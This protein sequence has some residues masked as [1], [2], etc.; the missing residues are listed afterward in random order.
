MVTARL[1]GIRQGDRQGFGLRPQRS[2]Q[3]KVRPRARQ[4]RRICAALTA[5][6]E[7]RLP[8]LRVRKLIA[9]MRENWMMD[10]GSCMP[11]VW[12]RGVRNNRFRQ[13]TQPLADRPVPGTSVRCPR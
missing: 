7:T 6:F 9:R 12:K 1:S 2:R 10:R 5:S 11:P 13:Y 3:A 4:L 8:K